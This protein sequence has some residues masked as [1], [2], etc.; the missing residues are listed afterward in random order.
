MLAQVWK[1]VYNLRHWSAPM[2]ISGRRS[3]PEKHTCAKRVGDQRQN[4]AVP[5]P[6]WSVTCANRSIEIVHGIPDGEEFREDEGAVDGGSMGDRRD[7][8]K[9]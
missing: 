8:G 9:R 7:V 5:A 3:L 6:G 2:P 4:R 1:T